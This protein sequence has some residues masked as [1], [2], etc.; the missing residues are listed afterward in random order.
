LAFL[1]DKS[2][3]FSI[4]QEIQGQIMPLSLS[5]VFCSKLCQCKLTFSH[6]LQQHLR[7][8][9]VQAAERKFTHLFLQIIRADENIKN[10][11]FFS[12]FQKDD[13]LPIFRHGQFCQ[14]TMW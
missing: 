2:N 13:F 3:I 11:A 1:G 5:Q 14:M 9:Q 8:I 6:R 12:K 10:D 7:L 4:I